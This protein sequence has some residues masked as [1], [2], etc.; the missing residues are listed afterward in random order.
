MKKITF[1]IISVILLV[2]NNACNGYKPIYGLSNSNFKIENNL[3]KGNE[4]LATLIYR[5]LYN[6]SLSNKNNPDS[7]SINL[8][9]DTKKERKPTIKNSAGKILE[10]EIVLNTNIIMD[11]FLTEKTILD[12]NFS[13]SIS[14]KVQDEH[15]ETIKLENKNIE[16]L[17]DKTYEDSLIKI[18]EVLTSQ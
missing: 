15:S 6:V 9:I 14:Y 18:S 10:Y 17:I 11:D 4:R 8:S 3:I 2:Q 5:K 16:N 12:H 7:Q 1:L 13:Y